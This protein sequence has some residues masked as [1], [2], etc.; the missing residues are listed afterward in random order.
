MILHSSRRVK[1][2]KTWKWC[3]TTLERT[4]KLRKWDKSSLFVTKFLPIFPVHEIKKSKFSVGW[5]ERILWNPILVTSWHVL[6]YHFLVL[7]VAYNFITPIT[8][9][10]STTLFVCKVTPTTKDMNTNKMSSSSLDWVW[11]L[12]FLPKREFQFTVQYGPGNC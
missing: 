11:R 8:K 5:T 9:L 7:D 10:E 12:Q 4:F 3:W 2:T 6:I 1:L